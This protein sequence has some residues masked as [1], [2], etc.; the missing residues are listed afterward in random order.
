MCEGC[1]Y[2]DHMLYFV[3]IAI[4]FQPGGL[5]G[6]I[7]VYISVLLSLYYLSVIMQNN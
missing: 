5:I 1:H 4:G 3:I 7:S 2:V 6:W